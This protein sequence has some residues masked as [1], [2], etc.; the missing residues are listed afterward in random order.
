MDNFLLILICMF[1]GFLLKRFGNLP[2]DAH[3][4][5]NTWILYI[6]LPA[7]SFKYIPHIIW[8]KELFLPVLTPLI[9]WSGA[10][11]TV[12]LFSKYKNLIPSDRA[13]L[14][15]TCGLCNTS[16]LGFPLVSAYFGEHNLST[17]IIVDQI[18]FLVFSSL[19]LITAIKANEQTNLS[20]IFI[21]K[22]ITKF[23]PFIGFVAALILSHFFDLSFFNSLFDKLA[24]TVS[25]LALFSIG[26]Q[27]SFNEWKKEIN[28]LSFGIFYKLLIAPLLVFLFS[29]ILQ[30]KGN[31]SHISIF[32]SAMPSLVSSY[33]LIDE[34]KLNTKLANLMI[35]LG[36]VFSLIT[37]YLWWSVLVNTI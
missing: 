21:L 20:I 34:Y 24:G 27:L 1:S 13:T 19:G 22:K 4:G 9:V 37:T 17:A 10:Y 14:I 11:I 28:N 16:F 23:P 31:I 12:S 29:L 18:N 33:L 15:L 35:G 7:V 26:L 32:E 36:I 5:I 25:P 6:A 2:H 3:K 8:T 30:I